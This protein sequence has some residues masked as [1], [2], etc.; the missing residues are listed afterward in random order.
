[1]WLTATAADVTQQWH[2]FFIT[3]YKKSVSDNMN[4]NATNTDIIIKTINA[5]LPVHL[6]L[7]TGKID[8]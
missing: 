1:M 3:Q 6:H 2:S 5:T 8:A 4:R 7:N